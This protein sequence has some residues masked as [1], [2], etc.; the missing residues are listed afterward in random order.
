[1]VCEFPDVFPEDLIGLPPERDVEF[2]IELKP[3][4]APISR[5]L[6]R[7]PPNEL[8]ELKT[9]L[10]DFLEKGSL[11]QVHRHGDVQQ[12]SSRRRIRLFEC[13]WT[14]DPSMNLLL[15]TSILMTPQVFISGYVRNLSQSRML[16]ENFYFSLAYVS[17]YPYYSYTFHRIWSYS[18]SQKA[19]FGAC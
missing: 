7:M 14:I 17:D 5:R 10:Q 11:D 9:Q 3:D 12:S 8:A 6:Y 18:V 4:M 2:V 1:V 15:R 13:A 19:E 16:S